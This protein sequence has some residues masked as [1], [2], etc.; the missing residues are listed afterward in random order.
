MSGCRPA[1]QPVATRGAEWFVFRDGRIRRSAPTTSSDRRRPNSRDSLTPSAAIPRRAA[2]QRDPISRKCRTE[3]RDDHRPS[4]IGDGHATVTINRPERMNALDEPTRLALAAAIRSSGSDPEVGAIVIT[5]A[6]PSF[7]RRPGPRRDPRTR[8][9]VRHRLT[10]VQ[11]DRRGDRIVPVPVIAAVNGAAVGAGMGIVL[12]MRH[13][14]DVEKASLT[15]VFGKVGL[16]PDRGLVAA[17]RERRLPAG[18]RA[19][20]DGTPRQRGRSA[21]LRSRL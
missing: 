6:G 18:V 15:C 2:V 7:L 20:G 10:N 12:G 9:C 13:R 21:R 8:R 17:V 19:G 11:P 14:P 1:D 4:D 16:V 3:K 5:G